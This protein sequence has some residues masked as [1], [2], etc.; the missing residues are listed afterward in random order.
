L[1]CPILQ[2]GLRR[3]VRLA[4]RAN[5]RRY[6][7]HLSTGSA[8]MRWYDEPLEVGTMIESGTYEIWRVE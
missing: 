6:L 3:G 2:N 7:V 5:K 1:D 4:R 8:A